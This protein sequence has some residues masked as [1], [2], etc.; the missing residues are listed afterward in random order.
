[1]T[2][3]RVLGTDRNGRGQG[4]IRVFKEN[5]AQKAVAFMRDWIKWGDAGD[6][7]RA[8]LYVNGE[9]KKFIKGFVKK[10]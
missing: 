4:T 6:T 3:I 5:E 1:M 8:I 2:N 10:A 7:V 9:Q